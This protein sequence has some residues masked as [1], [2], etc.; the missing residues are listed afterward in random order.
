MNEA[1]SH[2]NPSANE[3][4]HF[5]MKNSNNPQKLDILMKKKNYCQDLLKIQIEKLAMKRCGDIDFY[6]YAFV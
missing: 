3:S 4:L 5:H 1:K 2:K 6:A